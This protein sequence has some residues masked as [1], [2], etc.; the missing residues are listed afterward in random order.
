MN[1]VKI[2]SG[3]WHGHKLAARQVNGFSLAEITYPPGYKISKHAHES[4]LYYLVQ[5]GSFTQT[6]GRKT[7][8]GR[9]SSLI[10][11]RADE[12]HADKFHHAGA[13]CFV[14]ELEDDWLTRSRNKQ[15]VLD[16]SATF[17]GGMPA[18]FATRIYNE[19]R[20]M[21]QLSP[22]AIEGLVLEL[23]AETSRLTLRKAEAQPPRWLAQAQEF[24]HS[25]FSEPVSL[26]EVA[27]TVDMHSVHLARAFRQHYRCTI[28]EYIRKLRIEKAMQL[29][30]TSTYSLTEIAYLTGFSDQSHFTRIFKKH[31]GKNPSAYKKNLKKSNTD[32][33]S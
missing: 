18:W 17:Q 32:T 25:H 33:K 10:Y 21:D 8:E 28:G 31:T 14:I 13:L 16:N 15:Y 5:K 27:K 9:P 29:M 7:R 20:N 1:E 30:H 11:L 24:L 4:S 3:T 12:A 23:I 22:L 19:Y 26:S 6:Y 2:P